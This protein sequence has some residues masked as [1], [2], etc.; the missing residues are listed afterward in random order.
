[1]RFYC[2][3]RID[4]GN[5]TFAC[6]YTLFPFLPGN[7]PAGWEY[8][9]VRHVACFTTTEM[10]NTEKTIAINF[11]GKDSITLTCPGCF[12]WCS[13]VDSKQ[14]RMRCF[15]CTREIG[16]E[17]LFCGYCL[18]EWKNARSGRCANSECRSIEATLDILQNSPVTNLYGGTWPTIRLCPRCGILTEFVDGC[19]QIHCELCHYYYCFL[20]LKGANSKAELQCI[21]Y[22]S[23]CQRASLQTSIPEW[24]GHNSD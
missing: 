1:M 19:S 5:T 12:T 10:R 13:K 6:P 4:T 18:R 2:Q 15:I 11:A 22:N 20:C 8:R 3:D 23:P 7:C 14:T 21:P 24:D 9:H 16:K 17:F